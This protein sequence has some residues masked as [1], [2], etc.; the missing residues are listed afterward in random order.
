MSLI[1]GPWSIGSDEDVHGICSV[2]AVN[3]ALQEVGPGSTYSNVVL[4]TISDEEV[5]HDGFPTSETSTHIQQLR[6]RIETAL[7]EVDHSV[8]VGRYSTPH[9][10]QT[11]C[12]YSSDVD[13]LVSLVGR[14]LP[15][16]R[17]WVSDVKSGSDPEWKVYTDLL[18]HAVAGEGDVHLVRKLQDA[19]V[20][21]REVRTVDHHCL[22]NDEASA[23]LA[24]EE[25]FTEVSTEGPEKVGDKWVVTVHLNHS[26]EFGALA[27]YRHIL[28]RDVCGP[29]RGIYDGWGIALSDTEGAAFGRL[30]K[31]TEW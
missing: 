11:S 29:L 3:S 27:H 23:R 14:C 22:F 1:E 26:L 15:P 31:D 8:L 10:G 25:C 21:I 18:G 13:N 17:G 5:R 9:R 6:G 24:L 16:Y 4:V 19:G 20:D 7:K 2:Y 30:P 12:Y 28:K